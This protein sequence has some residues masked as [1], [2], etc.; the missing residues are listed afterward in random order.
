MNGVTSKRFSLDHLLACEQIVCCGSGSDH[1]F[2]SRFATRKE[3]GMMFDSAQT[4]TID[5]LAG[6]DPNDVVEELARRRLQETSHRAL[7]GIS[8][9][10]HDGVL[11]LHGRLPSYYLKQVAQTSVSGVEGVRAISNCV[12]V[13]ESITHVA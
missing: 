11:T 12:E 6:R 10:Y 3:D 9:R 4:R 8:C 7:R 2:L 5:D 1:A 13:I